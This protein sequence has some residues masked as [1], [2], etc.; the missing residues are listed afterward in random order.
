MSRIAIQELSYCRLDG[1][2]WGDFSQCSGWD[3]AE[4]VDSELAQPFSSS[5]RVREGQGAG[6][7]RGSDPYADG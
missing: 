5:V 7:R 4:S 2:P 1:G 6:R 3:T